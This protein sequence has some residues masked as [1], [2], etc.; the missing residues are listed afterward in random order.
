MIS[1]QVFD[2]DDECLHVETHDIGYQIYVPT[3]LLAHFSV[4]QKVKLRI[5]TH[6]REDLIQLFGFESKVQENMFC[7]LIKVNGIGPKVALGILSA[8]TLD[9]FKE[10]LHNKDVKGLSRLPKVGKKTAEQ[11]LLK[12]GELDWEKRKKEDPEILEN[13]VAKKLKLALVNLGFSVGDVH[14][15]VVGLDME[16]TFEENFKSSLAQLSQL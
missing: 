11:I 14:E 16:K 7:S 1:G 3:S 8:T 13:P 2:R 6:V 4:G 12:L 5:F 15:V 10:L 9:H